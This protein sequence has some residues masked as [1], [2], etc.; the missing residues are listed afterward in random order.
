[1]RSC[2]SESM[3]SY[4]VMPV[5]RCGTSETSIS[6]PAP[7]RDPISVVEQVSPAAPM[8][9]MPMSASVCI[10]SRHASSSSFSMNGSPTCTAGRFSR[11]FVVELR[12][13]HRRAVDAVA[14][15]L[16]ADVVDRVADAG[17]DALDD[18]GL[19]RDAEAEDVDQ[20]VAGVGRL[21]DDLAADGRDADA[22]AV[23]GDA[24]DDAFEQAAGAGRVEIAEA[25]RV[26]QRDRPRAHR[27]DVADDAADAGG[28]ALIR[29][30]ER[31]VV[32]RLDL[33]DGGEPVADVDRAGV[34]AR[35]PAA[36]AALRSAASSG[37]RASSCSCSARTTSPRRCRAR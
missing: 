3:I 36:P 2:D 12:R 37:A 29:L 31:R 17:G 5:S 30:D 6:T 33:E 8:S 27:E 34:L 9:W 15:G 14:A 18:V 25:Q 13:R 35:A 28:R 1:M 24:G 23:A 4:G 19:L 21:E 26:E 11:R 20:R 32:V 22:V 16:G 7:P 10:T